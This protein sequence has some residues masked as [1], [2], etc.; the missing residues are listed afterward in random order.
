ML[1][2]ENLL[3]VIFNSKNKKGR[4]TMK[5]LKTKDYEQM[6][7]VT[8]NILSAQ[9]IMKPRCVLGL[10]T[11]STPI[12]A[13]RQLID[14]YEKGDIDFSEVTSINIKKEN[15]Y[16]PDGLETDADR[17]CSRYNQIIAD[18]GGIDLQLLGLGNNGHIGFNEPGAAF[19]KE[20]HCVD[21]TQST[22][23]ANARFFSSLSE[24]PKQA[25]TMGIKTIMQAKKIVVAVSGAGKATDPV[26]FNGAKYYN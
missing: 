6:S 10:A 22:I 20:T 3:T 18:L 23:N 13:Y 8:A 12:G 16:V 2:S 9:V 5:I 26:F 25:Y 19:E 15:T 1:K 14:W 21:L 11:G 7:R 24:V 17:A 4:V